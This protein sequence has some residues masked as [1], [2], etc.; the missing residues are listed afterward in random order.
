MNPIPP[1][2]EAARVAKLHAYKILDTPAERAFDRLT[3]LVAGCFE[4]PMASISL[5]DS[6]RQWLKSHVGMGPACACRREDA[7]CAYAILQDEVTVVRDATLDPRFAGNPFVTG[8]PVIRFYA[9]A[10]LRTEDGFRL[11]T[12]C[13]LDHVPRR[14]SAAQ[15][16]MLADFAGT[17]LDEMTLRQATGRLRDEVR[18]H[19]RTQTVLR[20]KHTVLENLRGTLEERVRQRTVDFQQ[21]NT[22]LLVEIARREETDL[23]LHAAKEEA[24]QANRAKTEFLSRMSHELRTPL[25]AI[26]GFGQI[27]WTQ[28]TNETHQDCA[29]HVVSAGRQLLGLVNEVL[30]IS[31]LESGRL[32]LTLE[33]VCVGPVLAEALAIVRPLAAARR[34]R[35]EEP[36]GDHLDACWVLADRARF[37]Q[38]LL[39]LLSHAIK[40]APSESQVIV[41]CQPEDSGDYRVAVRDLG[42][43]MSREQ[44]D[45]LF[46]AFERL[47]S[48]GGANG[49]G[50]NLALAR[51]LVEAMHGGIG[52]QSRVGRGREFWMR[53]PGAV[54]V[55]AAALSALPALVPF[56]AVKDL[57]VSGGE[58]GSPTCTVLYIEDHASNVRLVEHLL[59]KYSWLRLLSASSGEIGLEL[60][61]REPPDLVLLDLHLPGMSGLEVLAALRADERTSAIP[62]AALSADATRATI[63]RTLDAG[64]TAYLTKPLNVEHLLHT[65]AVLHP[66]PSAG[67]V[68]LPVAVLPAVA[69]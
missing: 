59:A 27:L 35:L 19:R 43:G 2:D 56:P 47:D 36:P 58:L 50:V 53:L 16:R 57:P 29:Q 39:T 30:E 18:E 24:D 13:V 40:E 22:A 62:V 4:M 9:G 48:G 26:L 38:V 63:E 64:I 69:C 49:T 7:F 10:P 37:Q 32:R 51:H 46:V 17:V 5:I 14:F 1:A 42:P 8:Q 12:I 25:N 67:P 33:P 54:P 60:A 28:L 61:R 45:R 34:L 44:Q 68:S 66:L 65:L 20:R 23:A 15:K 55:P 11:G 6:D 52:V 31:R 41:A 21:A 3:R